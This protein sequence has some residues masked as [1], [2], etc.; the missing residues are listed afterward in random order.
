V[1]FLFLCKKNC[2]SRTGTFIRLKR[3][4]HKKNSN[5]DN[6]IKFIGSKIDLTAAKIPKKIA[7]FDI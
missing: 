6:R 7:N 1:L 3:H 5:K 4:V 2:F